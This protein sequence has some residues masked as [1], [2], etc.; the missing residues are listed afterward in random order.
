MHK[1]RT[2]CNAVE[3]KTCSNEDKIVSQRAEDWVWRGT[4]AALDEYVASAY[5]ASLM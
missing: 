2:N 1:N 3:K 4:H 5:V